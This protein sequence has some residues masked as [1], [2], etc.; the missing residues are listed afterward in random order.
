MTSTADLFDANPSSAAVCDVQF[1]SFGARTAFSGPCLTLLSH[2]DH[3]PVLMT[4]SVPGNGRVLVV[5]VRGSMRTGVLGDRLASKAVSNGWAGVIVHGV[6][7]DSEALHDLDV[8]IKAIG[9]TARRS[10]VERGGVTGG[11]VSFG[12]V[13]FNTGDWVYADLDAVIVAR[14]ELSLPS[15]SP[16][17]Y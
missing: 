1:R 6:I 11:P 3:R 10:E 12:G 2:E 5:D 14:S 13:T 16:A 9:T 8:G 17:S 15:T 7:R 4:L